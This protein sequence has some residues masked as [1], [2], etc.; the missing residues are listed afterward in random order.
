MGFSFKK[1]AYPAYSGTDSLCMA[2]HGVLF[3]K[4]RRKLQGRRGI[5]SLRRAEK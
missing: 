3:S 1:F 4:T 5:T 2:E